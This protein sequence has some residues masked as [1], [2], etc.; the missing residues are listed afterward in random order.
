[1]SAESPFYANIS[2]LAQHRP[3]FKSYLGILLAEHEDAFW[4]HRYLP[5]PDQLLQMSDF[6]SMPLDLLFRKFLPTLEQMRQKDIRFLVLDV[7]GV[8]TDGGMY[9]TE[10]G[11]EFKKFNTKDGL[12]IRK[13]TRSGFP[14]GIIS[15]GFLQKLIQRRAELLGIERVYV[16]R[17]PKMDIL[18]AWLEN[19]KLGWEQ[20]A[21]VGDDLNDLP[22]M[23]KAGL[24]A[25]PADA[26]LPLKHVADIVLSRKGGTGCIRELVDD[27]L[28]LVV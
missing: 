8:L 10:N 20:V 9:Y 18:A 24:A 14:V 19:M 7:D 17:E 27:Y 6:L 22:V 2:H 12:V 4:Q 25:C 3:G 26:M 15:S 28:Q 5:S 16:G 23:E 11:D 13:L 1:M 21:Y